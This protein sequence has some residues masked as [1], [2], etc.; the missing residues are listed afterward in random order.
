MQYEGVNE[1]ANDAWA[2]QESYLQFEHNMTRR[3]RKRRFHA[4]S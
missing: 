1:W 4:N 3:N 2:T